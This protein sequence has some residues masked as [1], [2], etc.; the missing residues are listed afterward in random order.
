[1]EKILEFQQCYNCG[2]EDM[3]IFHKMDNGYLCNLCYK[4]F[5]R[6]EL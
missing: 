2:I 3:G 4:K 6:D 5:C 1:M